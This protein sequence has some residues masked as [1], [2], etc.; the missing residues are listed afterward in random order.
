MCVACVVRVLGVGV[1]GGAR[2]RVLRAKSCATQHNTHNTT[3]TQTP[4]HTNTQQTHTTPPPA[5]QTNPH[6]T[7]KQTHPPTQQ[8][9]ILDK[10]GVELIGAKLP[11]IDRAED[12]ELF[13]QAMARIGLKVPQS[14]TANNVD[15]AL[16]IAAEI[17]RLPLISRPAFTCGGMGGG[18]AY[19]M[20]E[21]KQIVS[22]GFVCLLRGGTTMSG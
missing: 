19:N 20:E 13:K 16:A 2:E 1:L 12:R 22:G 6:P 15:E 14:G 5:Q 3:N 18:I 17:G 8:S 4:K 21:F 11:S 9:G 10:Y 7:P